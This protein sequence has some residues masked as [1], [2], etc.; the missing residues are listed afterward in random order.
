MLGLFSRIAVLTLTISFFIFNGYI[1]HFSTVWNYNTHI[2]FFLVALNFTRSGEYYSIDRLFFR[3]DTSLKST[4]ERERASIYISFVQFFVALIYWNAGYSKLI[5]G[6]LKW[7][8]EGES[9][10]SFMALTAQ[11]SNSNLGLELAIQPLIARIMGI[12]TGIFE[13]GFILALSLFSGSVR[14]GLI[15][16]AFHCVIHSSMNVPFFHLWFLYPALF[17]FHN[18]SLKVLKRPKWI[19]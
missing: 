6:G 14:L 11:Q 8:T 5:K 18:G 3:R 1:A 2:N 19:I 4:K 9:I 17:L 13:L 10:F 15:S 16:L 12:S 7:F